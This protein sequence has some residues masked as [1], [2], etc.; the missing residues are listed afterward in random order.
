[1]IEL[2]EGAVAGTDLSPKRL[3]LV[4]AVYARDWGLAESVARLVG[5]QSGR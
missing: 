1:M 5:T 4:F 3:A 2:E